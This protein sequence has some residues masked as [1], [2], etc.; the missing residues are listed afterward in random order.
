VPGRQTATRWGVFKK[1]SA[2]LRTKKGEDRYYVMK[3][4]DR[5]QGGGTESTQELR[6]FNIRELYRTV[7][8]RTCRSV[9]GRTDLQAWT[10]SFNCGF[11]LH[12]GAVDIATG[13]GLDGQVV[14]VRVPVGANFFP[15]FTSSNEYRRIFPQGKTARA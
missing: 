15:L 2:E 14:R 1:Q 5:W 4:C 9:H 10:L 3:Y 8:Y 7:V 12:Q 13:Y 6:C 11:R